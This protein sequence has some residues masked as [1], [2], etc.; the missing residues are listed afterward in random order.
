MGQGKVIHM[1]K[2]QGGRITPSEYHKKHAFPPGSKCLCGAPAE[3]R[4]IV[5]APLD[6][7]KKRDPSIEVMMVVNPER[8]M[9]SIVQI[10]ERP[11]DPKSAVKPYFR[12]SVTFGCARCRK[13]FEKQV[14]K[15]PSWC[16]VEFND[17]PPDRRIIVSGN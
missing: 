2:F 17:A 16:I 5:M 4:C 14:A 9:K 12:I 13:T 11:G 10:Q 1:K 3:F 6:E 15:A 8:F 7:A